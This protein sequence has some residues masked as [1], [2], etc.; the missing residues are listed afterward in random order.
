MFQGST[1][2]RVAVFP[3][4]FP[5]DGITTPPQICL[6]GEGYGAKI[7][8]GGLYRPDQSFVLF[9]VWINGW[10]LKRKDVHDIA[11]K[12]NID[13]VPII[14][15]GTLQAMEHMVRQGFNSQWGPFPAEGIVARPAVELRTRRGDRVITKLK[16]RDFRN[17][18]EKE[19]MHV[20][21]VGS[22]DL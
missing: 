7:Q 21:Y 19:I 8:K 2:P 1:Q 5:W 12:L 20:S 10:W 18:I 16:T 6:Y 15:T 9:D 14:G 17:A 22:S 4:L 11:A 3:E 13:R